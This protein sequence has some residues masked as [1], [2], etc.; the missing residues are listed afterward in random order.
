[1]FLQTTKNLPGYEPK[2]CYATV[3]LWF[4]IYMVAFCS[5][6]ISLP[7]SVQ[8]SL[9]SNYL[10]F[11]LHDGCPLA[12]P[13]LRLQYP[14]VCEHIHKDGMLGPS[15]NDTWGDRGEERGDCCVWETCWPV[16]HLIKIPS[17]P[18]STLRLKSTWLFDAPSCRSRSTLHFSFSLKVS[19]KWSNYKGRLDS[20]TFN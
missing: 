11:L 2:L 5:L 14:T 3:N 4:A 6:F 10:C 17:I 19:L 20:A 7:L 18:T 8:S 15:S 13:P 16:K 1:M 12:P 9:N